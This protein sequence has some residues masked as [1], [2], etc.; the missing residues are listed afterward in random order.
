M[1]IPHARQRSDCSVAFDVARAAAG[2]RHN[3]GPTA[4]CREYGERAAANVKA[5]LAVDSLKSRIRTKLGDT[6]IARNSQSQL[7]LGSLDRRL[8][9]LTSRQGRQGRKG[10]SRSM[11]RQVLTLRASTYQ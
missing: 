9:T 10:G 7:S 1:D 4:P 11:R 3:R 2:L 8:S 5:P 6:R